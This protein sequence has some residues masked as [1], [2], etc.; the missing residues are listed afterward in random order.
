MSD[1]TVKWKEKTVRV[2]G[3][4][5]RVSNLQS[6]DRRKQALELR[7]AGATYDE[8]AKAVGYS[9]P[10]AA[11]KAVATAITKI[12]VEPVLE[13]LMIDIARLDDMQKRCTAEMR[14][15]DL[16]QVDRIVRLMEKRWVL[17]GV[18]PE[19]V[20]ELANKKL[21][22]SLPE[23]TGITNNGVMLV[24]NDSTDFVRTIMLSLGVDPESP[25]AQRELQRI[26]ARDNKKK[27]PAPKKK[28]LKVKVKQGKPLAS[29]SGSRTVRI[30]SKEAG[31]KEGGPPPPTPTVEGGI[32]QGVDMGP[33]PTRYSSGHTEPYDVV[34][35][36]LIEEEIPEETEDDA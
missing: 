30:L 8:I 15:G 6:M 32:Y 23:K 5:T 36:E 31:K 35:A 29:L 14:K 22:V 19:V 12:Q 17:M 28:V 1:R 24:Q 3:R 27:K 7:K 21:G 20:R 2:N 18:T 9:G 11:Y 10:G 33:T 4:K 26:E 13:L 34:D 16:S 25:A